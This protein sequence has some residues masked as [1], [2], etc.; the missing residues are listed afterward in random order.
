MAA[1]LADVELYTSG[2]IHQW[3]AALL[4]YD[5]VVALKAAGR[6]KKTAKST[7]KEEETLVELDEWYTA[8]AGAC[9]TSVFRAYD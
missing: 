6:S 8:C 9:W 5:E 4:C 7:S 1:V 2:D 3:Q